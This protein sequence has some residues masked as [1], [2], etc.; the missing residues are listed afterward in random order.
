MSPVVTGEGERGDQPWRL[1]PHQ[2][3]SF[4]C[5]DSDPLR[6]KTHEIKKQEDQA[7]GVTQL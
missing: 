7:K 3:S 5:V 4:H 1:S 2:S 6:L